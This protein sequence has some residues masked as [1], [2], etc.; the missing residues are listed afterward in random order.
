[1]GGPSGH[2]QR[3]KVR[4]VAA[5]ERR[6]RR[7]GVALAHVA[8]PLRLCHAASQGRTHRRP[9]R[10]PEAAV[11]QGSRACTPAGSQDGRAGR[12]AG[13][14]G[15]VQE[16]AVSCLVCAGG[17]HRAG[18]ADGWARKAAA[19][20]LARCCGPCQHAAMLR[21]HKLRTYFMAEQLPC[22]PCGMGNEALS[23][24]PLCSLLQRCQAPGAAGSK[25]QVRCSA[26]RGGAAATVAGRALA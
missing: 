20:A 11:G 14:P 1:M 12:Q 4:S 6:R 23:A 15:S 16:A 25:A 13:A 19:K 7:A 24:Y 26:H 22:L 21:C 18:A 3:N 9:Q 8:I 17:R 5:A 10:T 2:G